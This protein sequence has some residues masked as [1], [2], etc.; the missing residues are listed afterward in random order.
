MAFWEARSNPAKLGYW[1]SIRDAL[2]SGDVPDALM[3]K[4]DTSWAGARP[5]GRMYETWKAVH[6]AF[7][8]LR[9]ATGVEDVPEDPED[10]PLFDFSSLEIPP[11]EDQLVTL[12]SDDPP[13]VTAPDWFDPP[14]AP[15]IDRPVWFNPGGGY[16][17]N[18]SIDGYAGWRELTQ[19]EVD[20]LDDLTD[21]KN[22]DEHG[23]C[24][25]VNC[26]K[27]AG[28][29]VTSGGEYFSYTDG[30]M[31]RKRWGPWE[32]LSP[33]V[34]QAV[35]D[36]GL[37]PWGSAIDPLASLVYRDS[38]SEN[39]WKQGGGTATYTGDAR[40][41]IRP[42]LQGVYYGTRDDPNTLLDN[43]FDD[44]GA[45]IRLILDLDRNLVD[46]E[47]SLRLSASGTDYAREQRYTRNGKTGAQ[48]LTEYRASNHALRKFNQEPYAT[49]GD[50]IDAA[51]TPGQNGLTLDEEMRVVTDR[52]YGLGLT[53]NGTFEGD[54][55]SGAVWATCGQTSHLTGCSG[56][57]KDGG[58]ASDPRS[59]VT[60]HI[61]R[62]MFVGHYVAARCDGGACPGYE[63]PVGPDPDK[64]E[65]DSYDS[66]GPWDDLPLAT[67]QGIVGLPDLPSLTEIN[68]FDRAKSDKVKLAQFI[69]WP[70][71]ATVQ[72]D[73]YAYAREL[74]LTTDVPTAGG[75]ATYTGDV[76]G[77]INPAHSDLSSPQ[78]ELTAD[79]DTASLD[80]GV[81]YMRS[82]DDQRVTL[83]TW[84]GLQI[85]SGAFDRAGLAGALHDGWLSTI[86]GQRVFGWN[87]HVPVAAIVG[88]VQSQHV[89]GVYA[90]GRSAPNSAWDTGQSVSRPGVNN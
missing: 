47:L 21:G 64:V 63:L 73:A 7:T 67:R 62:G 41:M 53:G 42:D 43:E 90:A 71:P 32:G 29:E 58:G 25:H 5:G 76:D 55:L 37:P 28:E 20:E 17:S 50:F 8:A 68:T 81:S 2:T 12:Q 3:A 59:H 27:S 82:S 69:S 52:W 16:A 40:G 60:G 38:S 66:W 65:V 39:W 44:G 36:I 74:T 22:V 51:T 10:P 84:A 33:E 80:A 34:Q 31:G 19:E 9:E 54:G 57:K 86:N 61:N 83:D 23:Q 48:V 13:V 78:I 79:F 26:G 45:R 1:Q 4:V 70:T 46:A 6:A 75:S 77:V 56:L 14:S 49:F 87:V 72:G 18:V 15:F 11:G 30:A 88:R 85:E 24:Q 89:V 35:T